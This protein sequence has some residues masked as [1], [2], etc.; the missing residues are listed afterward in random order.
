MSIS[1]LLLSTCS[2]ISKIPAAKNNECTNYNTICAKLIKLN[3]AKHNISKLTY[4]RSITLSTL[5]S[6]VIALNKI[7]S[8]TSVRREIIW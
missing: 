7:I 4:P 3:T 8:V 1:F 2:K 5:F 6:Y